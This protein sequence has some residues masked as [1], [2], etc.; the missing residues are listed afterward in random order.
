VVL[1]ARH[2][3]GGQVA[4]ASQFETAYDQM[5]NAQQHKINLR[6]CLIGGAATELRKNLFVS[7]YTPS[8]PFKECCVDRLNGQG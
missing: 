3:W 8:F 7:S 5:Y 4:Y 6:L 1:T 2:A